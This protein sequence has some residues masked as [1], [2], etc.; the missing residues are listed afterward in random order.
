MSK[1]QLSFRSTDD[2][3]ATLPI[4]EV[5]KLVR[6]ARGLLTETGDELRSLIGERYTD[7]LRSAEAFQSLHRI[8]RRLNDAVGSMAP[9][10]AVLSDGSSVCG[11]A[12]EEGEEE[13]E[14]GKTELRQHGASVERRQQN[15]FNLCV[16]RG[17]RRLLEAPQRIWKFL[18]ASGCLCDAAAEFVVAGHSW[19]WLKS[20]GRPVSKFSHSV[21]SPAA[22]RLW[23]RHWLCLQPLAKRIRRRAAGV[24]RRGAPDCADCAECADALAS[25]VRE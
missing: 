20:Y 5:R 21:T 16:A 15:S 25:M 1:Q 6:H 12:T 13:D 9:A 2:L 23:R 14:V 10:A 24:V 8:S 4:S 11:N 7:L 22:V 18:E 17:I 3:Y 19:R